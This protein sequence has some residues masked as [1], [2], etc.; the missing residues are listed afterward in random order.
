MHLSIFFVVL[1]VMAIVLVRRAN[2]DRHAVG[3][4]GSS[5][6]SS[7]SEPVRSEPSVYSIRRLRKD[8][9][10]PLGP[11]T[12]IRD[13]SVEIG[14]GV[15]AIVGPSGEGKTTLLNCIGGLDV[16]TAGEVWFKGTRLQFD[17]PEA[18]RWFRAEG[19]AWVFQEL[20]L[21][22]HQTVAE[23]VALPLL[24]RGSK[25]ADAL[26]T[27]RRMLERFG[28]GQL[29]E[30]PREQLSRGQQQRVAITRAFA[31]NAA[32]VLADEPTGSLDPATAELV[33]QEFRRMSQAEGKPV[34]LVTHNHDLARRYCDRVLL[35]TTDGL[36]DVVAG[37]PDDGHGTSGTPADLS[38]PTADGDPRSMEGGHA[39]PWSLDSDRPR[40][41]QTKTKLIE[42]N[43]SDESFLE[44]ETP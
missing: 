11:I 15:T 1:A 5:Q 43:P 3:V 42:L 21:I 34:I 27:A 19:V 14:S 28:I 31:S 18:M 29:S 22:T 4:R 37:P 12:A 30:R 20:N 9:P 6:R 13:V 23:N 24:C 39:V 8:Y 33:M 32:V 35:C 10:S 36:R 25:R 41:H 44:K 16:P 7:G 38:L 26:V 17:A 2:G 40:S